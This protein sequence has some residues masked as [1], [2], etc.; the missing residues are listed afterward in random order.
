MV[1]T[2][3]VNGYYKYFKE[4]NSNKKNILLN[5]W[6]DRYVNRWLSKKYLKEI[7]NNEE[8]I[9]KIEIVSSDLPSLS[10]DK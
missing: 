5:K 1:N 8:Y 3:T 6:K 10:E 2:S 9:N 7:N 4:M